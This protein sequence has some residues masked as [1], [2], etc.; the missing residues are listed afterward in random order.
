MD[1]TQYT[2]DNANAAPPR[3]I[4]DDEVE[5]RARVKSLV[6]FAAYILRQY[7]WALPTDRA[8]AF[9]KIVEDGEE[10]FP[11]GDV[12]LIAHKAEELERETDDLPDMVR[13]LFWLKAAIVRSISP[14]RG[15]PSPSEL[16][17]EVEEAE[18]A[19]KNGDSGAQL[20]LR[21]VVEKVRKAV[22]D[23]EALTCRR[24]GTARVRGRCPQGCDD[25]FVDPPMPNGRPLRHGCDK[26][27]AIDEPAANDA[28]APPQGAT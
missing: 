27:D 9:A 15:N 5:I 18:T 6:D 13:G 21:S 26:R 22:E 20:R 11:N 14:A 4:T 7:S 3:G 12:G 2:H 17:K 10:A 25:I 8:A 19:L 28:G 16:M 1:D 24:C 23:S